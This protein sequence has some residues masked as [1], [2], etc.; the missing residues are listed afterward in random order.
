MKEKRKKIPRS[1][2]IVLGRVWPGL[3][4]WCHIYWKCKERKHHQQRLVMKAPIRKKII[5]RQ[6]AILS[7]RWESVATTRHGYLFV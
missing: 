6:R 4:K 1:S 2:W 5:Q 7:Q 3:N